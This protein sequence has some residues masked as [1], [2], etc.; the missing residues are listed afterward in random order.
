[1]KQTWHGPSG[2]RIEADLGKILMDR[3]LSDSPP[4]D[5]ATGGCLRGKN[6]TEGGDR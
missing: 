5:N 1:M 6:S 4:R 3:F 2:F